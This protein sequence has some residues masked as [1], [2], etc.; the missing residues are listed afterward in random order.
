MFVA[1]GKGDRKW[2]DAGIEEASPPGTGVAAGRSLERNDCG[3]GIDSPDACESLNPDEKVRAGRHTRPRVTA[4]IEQRQQ[5]NT[6]IAAMMEV[7]ELY[8]FSG[9][10]RSPGPGR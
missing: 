9:S 6:A 1:S 2:S 3:E 5:L 4:D 7:N 10:N 8:L